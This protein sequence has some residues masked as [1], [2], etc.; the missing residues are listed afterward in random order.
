MRGTLIFIF[1]FDGTIADTFPAIVKISNRL[2]EEFH[3]NKIYPE[4][5]PYLKNKTT[6]EV[7]KYL[8][9]PI[10]KI[11]LIVAKA[12]K[13]LNN[14]MTSVKPTQGLKNILLSL[15]SLGHTIG[16]LTSNSLENVSLFLKN[17]DLD[18]F[19]FINTTSKI[20]SKNTGLNN[21]ISTNG[22]QI[23]RVI[24]IGDETRDIDAAR[25]AGVRVAAVAWGYNSP[26]TLKAHKPDYLVH[27][28]QELIQ[29]GLVPSPKVVSAYR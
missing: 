8:K 2:A 3:F 24:Y 20:W 12:K 29:L 16:I 10:M 22:F 28:P 25:K 1:D 23:E 13:E 14:E 4:E 21:L 26:S 11:P 5:I 27:H 15:K 19:D 9:V 17:H 18:I 6:H 7:I